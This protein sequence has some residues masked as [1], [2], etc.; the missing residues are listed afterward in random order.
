MSE[1]GSALLVALAL[2]LV[3]EGVLPFL[4]PQVWRETFLKLTTLPDHQLRFIGL[5]A[6]IAGLLL[7]YWVH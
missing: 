7:L 2:L 6:M 4:A 5:T 1:L 3:L